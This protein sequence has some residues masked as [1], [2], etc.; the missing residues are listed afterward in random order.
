MQINRYIALIHVKENEFMTKPY[1]LNYLNIG[2]SSQM[3]LK[4]LSLTS[5]C[6]NN[7]IVY[8]EDEIKVLKKLHPEAEI[9]NYIGRLNV[10]KRYLYDMD[11]FN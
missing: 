5:Q 8:F 1:L 7:C 3:R 10:L 2:K 6:L 11:V 4:D 9:I